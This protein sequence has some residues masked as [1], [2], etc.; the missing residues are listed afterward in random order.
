MPAKKELTQQLLP[1]GPAKD[2]QKPPAGA[3]EIPELRRG[4]AIDSKRYLATNLPPLYR[5]PDIFADMASKAQELGFERVLSQL[6]GR[7]LRVATMCSG[8]EAPLLALELIQTGLVSNQQ[9]RI[10]HAFSCEIVPFKQSY[11]ERNFRPP[12]LFRDITELGGEKA[13]TAYGSLEAIPGGLDILIAGTACVDFSPLNSVQKSL[14]QGG[15]SA[16]TFGGLLQ[17]A[18][19]YRPQMVIQENVR[20]APWAQMKD[21]WEKLGYMC[22]QANVDTKHYYIPQTRERGYMVIIDQRRLKEVGLIN[23]LD[24]RGMTL[25]G[26]VSDLIEKFKRPA[27]A[28]VGQFMLDDDD[29]RLELIEMK[30]CLESRSEVSWEQYK[31]RHAQHRKDLAL[32]TG[33]PITRSLPGVNDLQAPDFYWH[34]FWRTQP[35]RVWDTIDINFLKRMLQGYDMNH[36][37]RWIDLSQGVDRSNETIASAGVAGCITPKGIPFST[38]RGGPVSGTEALSLQGLPLDRMLLTRETNADLMDMA[39]NAMTSTVVCAVMLA[40]L[41]AVHK[42]LDND[43]AG[44]IPP[45]DTQTP[46]LVPNEV[47]GFVR[48]TLQV[49]DVPPVDQF[50][51]KAKAACSVI[52]CYC[53]RQTG[54]HDSIFLCTLCGHTAC[55]SCRGNPTHSYRHVSPLSRAKPSEF[56]EDV[57]SVVP[58][59]IRLSGLSDSTFETFK[60]LYSGEILAQFWGDFLQCTRSA[61]HDQFRFFEIKRGRKWRVVYEGDH[62]NLFLE[63]GPDS[64]QWLLY[65]KPPESASMRSPIRE[66]LAKPIARMSPGPVSLLRGHWDVSSPISTLLSLT[67]TGRGNHV[68][69]FQATCGL[70]D[71]IV[72]ESKVWDSLLVQGP[73]ENGAVLDVDVEGVYNWLPEC[74]TALG[75]LYRR[76]DNTANR[77]PVFLYLD[78]TKIGP[79]DED[80]C[81]FALEH[82]RRT[83]YD[84]RTTIAELSPTWRAWDV[85]SDSQRVSA[86]CRQW[87]KAPNVQFVLCDGEHIT[88]DTLQPGVQVSIGN[89]G[90]HNASVTLVSLG[91]ST[92]TINLPKATTYWQS[93]DP[94]ASARELKSLAWLFPKISAWSDFENWSEILCPGSSDHSHDL[95]DN[96]DTCNPP[97]PTMIWGRDKAGRIMP[98]E[99]PQ[100]AALYEHAIKTR[101]SP[102]LVFRRVNE[103]GDAELR[104][105]LNVQALTHQAQGK[106]VGVAGRETVKSHWRL[107]PHAYDMNHRN[108]AM[109]T[110][111]NNKNDA[112]ALQP[113]N[114]IFKLRTEQLRSL[115]WMVSQEAA[116]IEPFAE[117]EV[118]EAILPVMPWRAEVKVTMPKVIRGGVLA[119]EVGYGKTAIVLALIDAQW[120]KDYSR[121]VEDHGLIPTN[122]T[123]IIVP[124]NVFTQWVSECKKFLGSMYNVLA[125]STNI[126]RVTIRAVQ[127]ADIVILSWSVLG[128]DAYYARLQRFTGAPQ[129]PGKGNGPTGRNFESWF[130]DA[131]AS[132]RESV[133]TLR[134]F[135]PEAMLQQLEARRRRVQ[136]TQTESTYVPSRRLRGKAFAAAN[137][138]S[139]TE[140]GSGATEDADTGPAPGL[141]DSDDTDNS[142]DS[143]DSDDPDSDQVSSTTTGQPKRGCAKEGP[144]EKRRKTTSS[145]LKTKSRTKPKAVRDDRAEFNI[146]AGHDQDWRIVKGAFLHAFRFNRVVIDEYTYAGEGKEIALL[147]LEAR[148]KWVL[149]G[150]PALDEFADIKSIALYLG[151]NLGIDDDGDCEMPSKNPR[152]RDVRKRYTKVEAFQSYHASRSNAWYSN[153]RDLA[154]RFLDRYARQNTAETKGIECHQTLVMIDPSPAEAR[155]YKLLFDA[156][157]N[158]TKSV[159]GPVNSILSRKLPPTESLVMCSV[160]TQVGKQNWIPTQEV[161]KNVHTQTLQ[162]ESRIDSLISEAVTFW[163]REPEG[164]AGNPTATAS[165]KTTLKGKATETTPEDISPAGCRDS[166]IAVVKDEF[167]VGLGEDFIRRLRLGFDSYDDRKVVEETKAKVDGRFQKALSLVR[168]RRVRPTNSAGIDDAPAVA[169]SKVRQ[170]LGNEILAQLKQ[171]AKLLRQDRYNQHLLQISS[172]QTPQCEY[173]ACATW[174]VDANIHIIE[175]CGHALCKNCLATA[176][177]TESCPVEGCKAKFEASKVICRDDVINEGTTRSSKLDQLVRIIQNTPQDELVI[178]F[179]QAPTLVLVTSDALRNAGIEHRKVTK[180]TGMKGITDFTEGSKPKRGSSEVLPRPK[181]LLLELGSSMAAGLNLQCAN[182]VIF[183]SP[184]IAA[185]Q[186]DYNSGMTQAIGRARRYGQTRTVYVYHLLVKYT[187]DVNVYQS[188]HGG[189]LVERGGGPKVVPDSEVGPGDTKYEGKEMPVK[190]GR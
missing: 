50:A 133:G 1:Y 33:R 138:G 29:R 128:G 101:P 131:R 172:G 125:I 13:R 11:I 8:T 45:G 68:P 41:I 105:T 77:P 127:D 71:P 97:G 19:K 92:A 102:F 80:A 106:L 90:C 168:A 30:A 148:S 103:Q 112:C 154:Q 46:R 119:D 21:K 160:V 18:E 64:I 94:E 16:A 117:E 66:I 141:D 3:D 152:L 14:Q 35:E 158:E 54:V 79:L 114:F 40:G 4:R 173:E 76:E 171:A 96:C 26:R 31:I 84:A 9:F 111:M 20:G 36:K 184:L 169:A 179:I 78:Q 75:S 81:V 72:N 109:F 37:E 85:T 162:T 164:R 189:R 113:P 100:E 183:L 159:S 25:A 130:N 51:M 5:L 53:E 60:P 118:E 88:L 65:A 144:A 62:S 166:L 143:E 122:A 87:A 186:R 23:P 7:P 174:E 6:G 59:K 176:K 132:L 121:P 181:A 167:D 142:N 2:D 48:R 124:K 17:Y 108:P 153:R 34:R 126:N 86:S 165:K 24:P 42:I 188:A 61:V 93:W 32:G 56:I 129:A 177:V 187:Y 83:G 170:N 150:T 39:G 63:I 110:L 151:L 140:N 180:T 91:A 155:N 136:E 95:R 82:N 27:S 116:D 73:C 137:H 58:M 70:Q 178:V 47:Y 69:S 156:L 15:E 104:F 89:H 157:E 139:E 55:G 161:M 74:G 149:S 38:T 134:T 185:T 43:K 182:H 12:V 163:Y 99:N 135:G 120:M 175:V 57:K 123:L 190:T 67:I 22:V 49:A 147:S 52:C 98:I 107:L 10:S 115:N 145:S 28:P 146:P 44:S